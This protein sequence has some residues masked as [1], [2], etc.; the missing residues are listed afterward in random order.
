MED[1]MQVG[2]IIIAAGIIVGLF[3]TVTK[4]VVY[5]TKA[6]SEHAMLLKNI[7]DI[8]KTHEKKDFAEH[9]EFKEKLEDNEKRLND[10]ETRLQLIE[11][12]E[13]DP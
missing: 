7:I 8:F 1:A 5:V 6:I 10:H 11:R 9:S 13:E 2:E 12:N 4:P 3:F